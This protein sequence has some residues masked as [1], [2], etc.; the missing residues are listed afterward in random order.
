VASQP[1]PQRRP[2][3]AQPTGRDGEAAARLLECLANGLALLL[4]QGAGGRRAHDDH[5]AQQLRVRLQQ[6]RPSSSGEQVGGGDL[7]NHAATGY[8]DTTGAF[9][10]L[11]VGGDDVNAPTKKRKGVFYY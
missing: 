4:G 1:P 9:H 7:F 3:D 11:V 10:I 2:A 8:L 5:L 6:H